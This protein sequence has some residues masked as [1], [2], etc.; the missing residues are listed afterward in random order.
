[1][2]VAARKPQASK[3][4]TALLV[5]D[6]ISIDDKIAEL[7]SYRSVSIVDTLD[8]EAKRAATGHAV[9]SSTTTELDIET[10]LAHFKINSLYVQDELSLDVYQNYTEQYVESEVAAPIDPGDAT[11]RVDNIEQEFAISSIYSDYYKEFKYTDGEFSGYRIYS[12]SIKTLQLFDVNFVFSNGILLE[13]NITRISDG[14]ILKVTYQ[15][16]DDT[17][18]GLSRTII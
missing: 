15:Y 4:I 13:K 1:M 16:Q 10:K 9:F 7:K 3:P 2:P 12:N 14:R 11:G 8:I 17:L 18:I 6:F 5:R